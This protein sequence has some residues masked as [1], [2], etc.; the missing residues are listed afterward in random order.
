M[1]KRLFYTVLMSVALGFVL[2]NCDNPAGGNEIGAAQKAADEFKTNHAAILAKPVDELTLDDEDAINNALAAYGNL[3]AEAKALLAG[4]NSKLDSNREKLDELING[5]IVQAGEG[6]FSFVNFPSSS[7]P[8]QQRKYFSLSQGKMIAT[9][10]TAEWDIA[11]ESMNNFCYIYTNSGVTAAELGSGGKGGVWF[12]TKGTNFN[13]ITLADRVTNLTGENTEYADYVTDV[14]RYQQG[15]DNAVA[16]SMNIMTYYGYASGDGSTEASPFGWSVPGPPF[17]SFFEF[18][19]KAFAEEGNG[20][21]PP[22]YPTQQVYIIGHGDGVSYSKF[23]ITDITYSTKFILS[24]RFKNLDET[25][26]ADLPAP[27]MPGTYTAQ[28]LGFGLVPLKLTATFSADSGGDMVID[29]IVVDSHSESIARS[30][31]A[32]AIATIPP[33]IVAQQKL[34][35]D[36]VSGATRTSRAILRAVEIC[37]EKAGV[38][39]ADLKGTP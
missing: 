27:F 28:A 19:K 22:W 34:D 30:G 33:A 15:M 20:M 17:S 37:A 10:N 39:P 1:K 12:T 6:A 4:E 35:V 13:A 11:I 8:G 18:N 23:Q 7:F 5:P 3:S 16:G 2:G 24:F 32:T 29:S 14:T 36:T 9:K 31:V 38:N 21:P 25:T 26:E